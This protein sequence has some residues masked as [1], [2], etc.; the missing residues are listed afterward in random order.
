VTDASVAR[1]RGGDCWAATT[2]RRRQHHGLCSWGLTTAAALGDALSDRVLWPT[3][4]SCPPI[5]WAVMK[6]GVDLG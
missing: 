4:N 1:S 5:R 3:G 6:F 2:W